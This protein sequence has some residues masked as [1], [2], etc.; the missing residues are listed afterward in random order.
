MKVRTSENFRK[1]RNSKISQSSLKLKLEITIDRDS[2]MRAFAYDLYTRYPIVARALGLAA[3]QP[4]GR[5][6]AKE[7]CIQAYDVCNNLGVSK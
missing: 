7:S 3:V 6:R 2:N 5:A 4:L 1:N